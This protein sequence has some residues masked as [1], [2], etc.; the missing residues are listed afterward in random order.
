MNIWNKVAKENRVKIS[1][2][3]SAWYMSETFIEL[4][5]PFYLYMSA[6]IISL[7]LEKMD[8][9]S[10]CRPFSSKDVKCFDFLFAFLYNKFCGNRE[11]YTL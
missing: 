8:K 10:R 2:G 5:G 4:C 9:L 1:W 3:C 6:I 11:R 7:S